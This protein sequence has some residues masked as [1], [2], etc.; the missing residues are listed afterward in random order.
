MSL[1]AVRDLRKSY[2]NREGAWVEIV[3]IPSF[4]VGEGEQV[5]IRGR[6]GIGKTTFLNLIAGIVKADE[7]SVVLDEVDVC[8]LSESKRD[9]HRAQI[10][11][12][13]FQSFNL[14]GGYTCLENVELGMSFGGKLDRA[15]AKELLGKVGLFD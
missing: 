15:Y 9:L 2:R 3:R 14:L 7:G 4:E 1:L 11:G 6:S 5:A 10:L 12:Y 13:V 8:G